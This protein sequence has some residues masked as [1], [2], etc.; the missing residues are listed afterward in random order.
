MDAKWLIGIGSL[1]GLAG[2]LY[3]CARLTIIKHRKAIDGFKA[4]PQ[5]A[6][7]AYLKALGL[8]PA[9]RQAELAVWLR[10][11]IAEFG[12]IPAGT[13]L[14]EHRIWKDYGR[15]PFYDS[16][17]N[18]EFILALEKKLN[19]SIPDE[20]AERIIPNDPELTVKGMTFHLIEELKVMEDGKS[21][22]SGFLRP[23]YSAAVVGGLLLFVALIFCL[24]GV[25][26]GLIAAIFKSVGFVRN[27]FFWI[28]GGWTALA[29]I[30]WVGAVIRMLTAYRR[31]RNADRR[32]PDCGGLLRFV[33]TYGGD[34]SGRRWDGYGFFCPACKG[35]VESERP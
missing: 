22:I 17:D 12:R 26:F 18:V 32:C 1:L 5:M 10:A 7:D 20:Q 6:D 30:C 14:P 8:E 13:V 34:A 11:V 35:L 19:I 3:I 16:P 31:D 33:K 27:L 29:V 21:S 24:G 28:A 23:G 9:S 25:I 2:F 4:G 15:L